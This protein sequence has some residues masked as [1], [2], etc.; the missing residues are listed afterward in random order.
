MWTLGKELIFETSSD[1]KEMASKL[2]RQSFDMQSWGSLNSGRFV[3]GGRCVSRLLEE[4]T[5]D[6]KGTRKIPTPPRSQQALVLR[7]LI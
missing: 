1:T 2:S 6:K 5:R 7:G 3:S 4:A